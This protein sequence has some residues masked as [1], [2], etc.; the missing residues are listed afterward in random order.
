MSI[1]I[2][3]E[4][5][6][7][8]KKC[9]NPDITII[10]T[11]YNQGH[12]LH[13]GLRSV[14]N[15]SLKNL[16]IIIIDDC[17]ED[18]SVD[19]IKKYQ[20]ED[21]RI[22]L[23]SH[24]M[25]EGEIKSRTDGIRKAKGKYITIIDGDDA[26]IHENILKN[27]L[28]IAQKAKL[29]V[30]EFH[31]GFFVNGTMREI[32]YNYSK[33]NISN[34][35]YQPE[36]RTKFV[37][38]KNKN[39]FLQNRVIW[40]KLIKKELFEDVLVYLGDDIVDDYNNEAEDTLML[41]GIFHLAKSY[42]IMKEIGYYY[43]YGEKKNLSPHK[44]NRICKSNNKLKKMGW[45]KYLKFLVDKNI[46]NEKEKMMTYYEFLLINNKEILKMKLDNRHYKLMFYV[47]DKILKF[48]NLNKTQKKYIEVIKNKT[49]K[50]SHKKFLT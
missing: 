18:N 33:I 44:P 10:I 11:I 34:I 43:S 39:C 38:Q 31:A 40:A 7:K 16:E 12:C 19:I 1:N 26:L 47:F 15:Q 17:S 21:E 24:N 9:N 49:I 45:Y 2:I 29:D 37:F 41:V 8:F 46:S 20:E 6:N 22:I 32:I 27:S 35:I 50:K 36:L 28:Y 23:I 5:N 13:R 4:E 48:D 30:V 3:I 42:Y 25:N 14:Q